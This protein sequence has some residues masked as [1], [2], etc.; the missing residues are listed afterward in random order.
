MGYTKGISIDEKNRLLFGLNGDVSP[1]FP[2][3][4][5]GYR[6]EEGLR[7]FIGTGLGYRHIFSSGVFI[8]SELDL[9]FYPHQSY[10]KKYSAYADLTTFLP[11]AKYDIVDYLYQR[12]VAL[13]N[14][15]LAKGF[16]QLKIF[17]GIAF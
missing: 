7:G 8:G 17:F 12:Q 9:S 11:N 13:E 5:Y 6:I 10:S 3:Q 4:Q 14:Y 1:A 15:Q 2:K 16:G